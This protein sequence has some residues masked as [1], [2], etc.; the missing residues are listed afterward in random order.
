M[1][2]IAI[3]LVT[4]LSLLLITA[5]VT[6]AN[7]GPHGNYS[8]LEDYCA[9]CHR[10]HTAVQARTLKTGSSIYGLCITCRD[11]TSADTNVIDGDIAGRK[12]LGGGFDNFGG[13]ATT[14]NH[15]ATGSITDSW[16]ASAGTNTGQSTSIS[17]VL[18]CSSCHNPHGSTLYRI[19]NPV[20]NNIGVSVEQS[21]E[22]AINEWERYNIEQY[23]GG[24]IGGSTRVAGAGINGFCGACHI[25]YLSTLSYSGSNGLTAGSTTHYRH[26]VGMAWDRAD[27][28]GMPSTISVGSNNPESVG[29]NG[30]TIPLAD[31]TGGGWVVKNGGDSRTV[32]CLTCHFAHGT[33]AT[34]TGNAAVADNPTGDSSL[35]RLSQRGVCQICHQKS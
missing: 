33:T 27:D 21:D 22:W 5:R 25:S 29:F 26:R 12:L 17:A 2:R 11:G 34:G 6:L 14:S 16:G 35:L 10:A 1:Y 18:T 3:T 20:V 15:D 7:K 31:V 24:M 4:L 30:I 19:L 32:V 8:A 9:A 23:G 13:S 28:G